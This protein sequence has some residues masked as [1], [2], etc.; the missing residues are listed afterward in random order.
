MGVLSR[1]FDTSETINTYEQLTDTPAMP[2]TSRASAVTF[3]PDRITVTYRNSRFRLMEISG[4]T[5]GQPGYNTIRRYERERDVPG[6]ARRYL[7]E[8]MD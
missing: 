8:D 7:G 4:P 1:L 5:N 3:Q 6:W 2:V